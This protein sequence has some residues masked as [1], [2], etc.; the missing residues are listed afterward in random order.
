MDIG[1]PTLEL[2]KRFHGEFTDFRREQ[3]SMRMRLSSLEQHYATVSGD[4]AQIRL[5]LDGIRGHIAQ[6]RRRLDLVDA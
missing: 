5:E 1:E 4:L 6:I 2:L 3:E